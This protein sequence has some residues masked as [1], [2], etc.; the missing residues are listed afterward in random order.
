[1]FGWMTFVP[2]CLAI[3]VSAS[4]QTWALAVSTGAPRKPSWSGGAVHLLRHRNKRGMI[5]VLNSRVLYSG[6][7]NVF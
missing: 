4:A 2:G 3:L 6:Y 5:S 7:E 1:M